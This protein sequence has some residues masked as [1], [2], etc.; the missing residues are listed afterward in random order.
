VNKILFPAYKTIL[1]R[2][3]VYAYMRICV[4]AYPDPILRIWVLRICVSAQDRGCLRPAGM[5]PGIHPVAAHALDDACVEQRLDRRLRVTV[6]L[7]G[8]S[9]R[10]VF[11]IC[12]ENLACV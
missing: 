12:R 8:V 5:T 3:C 4:Y 7:V 11:V 10:Y 1:L 6:D 9:E 2:I